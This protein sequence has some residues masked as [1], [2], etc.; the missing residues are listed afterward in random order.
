MWHQ[1]LR[2]NLSLKWK[3]SCSLVKFDILIRQIWNR[4]LW[5]TVDSRKSGRKKRVFTAPRFMYVLFTRNELLSVSLVQ[6][7]KVCLYFQK[8]PLGVFQGTFC[9]LSQFILCGVDNTFRFSWCMFLHFDDIKSSSLDSPPYSEILGCC[10]IFSV[11]R[12]LKAVQQFLYQPNFQAHLSVC[13][14]FLFINFKKGKKEKYNIVY[15]NVFSWFVSTRVPLSG[16]IHDQWYKTLCGCWKKMTDTLETTFF[17]QLQ[18]RR[19]HKDLRGI[20]SL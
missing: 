14:V 1:C 19:W 11:P 16:L 12:R 2:I 5:R 4:S 3:K 9:H 18:V 20:A 10:K 15:K 17:M 8:D 13:W 6:P 7:R